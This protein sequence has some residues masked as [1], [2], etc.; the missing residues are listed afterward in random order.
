[1]INL[2]K[3]CSF[4][5]R[6]TAECNNPHRVAGSVLR[7]WFLDQNEILSAETS[8]QCRHFL[9]LP[10]Q[11][12]SSSWNVDNGIAREGA[13]RNG[14][15]PRLTFPNL[16]EPHSGR[17]KR[18]AGS[19]RHRNLS[20]MLHV[21]RR[22]FPFSTGCRSGLEVGSESNRD[23]DSQFAGRRRIEWLLWNRLRRMCPLASRLFFGQSL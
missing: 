19:S 21:V 17:S 1:M 8:A 9:N 22:E 7:G 23:R 10:N 5:A 13:Y 12:S 16:E 4:V 18:E 2:A 11:E 6:R 3:R 14:F 20:E 15:R